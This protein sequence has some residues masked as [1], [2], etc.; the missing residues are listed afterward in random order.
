MS[1][2]LDELSDGIEDDGESVQEER[3]LHGPVKLGS[4]VVLPCGLVVSQLGSREIL[5]LKSLQQGVGGEFSR[6]EGVLDSF[7]GQGID[8][9]GGISDDQEMVS[10][11]LGDSS[12]SKGSSLHGL[13]IGVGSKS[14]G[15]VF[16][17]LQ[18][19]VM[20]GIEII[21][22]G[23]SSGNDVSAEVEIS[24]SLSEDGAISGQELGGIEDNSIKLEEGI[25]LDV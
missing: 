6:L 16:V 11:C 17:I 1:S 18:D 21:I 13:S 8:E 24:L 7:S 9:S 3:H 25:V 14:C 20:D 15:D 19:F 23:G 4:P 2:L 22:L 5:L 10:V 12:Q